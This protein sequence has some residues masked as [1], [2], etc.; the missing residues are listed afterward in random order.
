[1]SCFMRAVRMHPLLG[2][3]SLQTVIALEFMD[4][5]IKSALKIHLEISFPSRLEHPDEVEMN[6]E[7]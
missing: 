3:L 7:Y 4:A 2:L 6:V 5:D 1:M